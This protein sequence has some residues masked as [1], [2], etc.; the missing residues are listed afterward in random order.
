MERQESSS[1]ALDDADEVNEAVGEEE[2]GEE[3]AQSEA[4][5][6]T[7]QSRVSHPPRSFTSLFCHI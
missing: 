1:D 7:G 5:V 2:G 3:G 4:N 6:R